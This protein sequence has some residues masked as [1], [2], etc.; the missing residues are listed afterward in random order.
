MRDLVAASPLGLVQRGVGLGAQQ[1][2]RVARARRAHADRDLELRLV[3]A[4]QQPLRQ[5]AH[6]VRVGMR[7][8]HGELVS[9]DAEG[10]IP[11][12]PLAQ[13][14]RDA[15]Q[16]RIAVR[17]TVPVVDELEVVDVESHQRQRVVLADRRRH[18]QREL[19]LKCALVRQV[20]QA[21][22]RCAL[23]SRTVAANQRASPEQIEHAASGQQCQQT[24]QQKATAEVGQRRVEDRALVVADLQCIAPAR[25]VHGR[26]ELE[27]GV[28]QAGVA[29]ASR[30]RPT[31]PKRRLDADV[32]VPR[33]HDRS[34]ARCVNKTVRANQQRFARTRASRGRV[35]HLL[36]PENSLSVRPGMHAERL[37]RQ[38]VAA[39][40]VRDA[41][42]LRGT[43]LPIHEEIP[44]QPDEYQ[45]GR[46]RHHEPNRECRTAAIATIQAPAGHP[47]QTGEA[48]PHSFPSTR[49]TKA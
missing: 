20:G 5:H 38:C 42:H 33:S 37:E 45:R 21:I 27:I 6:A 30:I 4:A 44:Q 47:S 19:V 34:L 41:I 29:L 36:D 10:P 1:I 43:Q 49:A 32:G 39:L 23:Q 22:A 3:Q 14:R 24:H 12:A 13:H 31:E 28:I 11:G 18:R 46:E 40:G 8:E 15:L 2:A 7:Q 48:W 17:V 35:Q 16:D 25:K 9:A 26:H